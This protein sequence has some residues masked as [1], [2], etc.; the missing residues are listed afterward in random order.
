MLQDYKITDSQKAA[1]DSVSERASNEKLY[2]DND[3]IINANA[4]F[5][6][7][8]SI[9][10]LDKSNTVFLNDYEY[11]HISIIKILN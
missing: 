8:I 2:E 9:S 5:D 1:I 3:Y 4:Q 7:S 10:S 11:K 6:E